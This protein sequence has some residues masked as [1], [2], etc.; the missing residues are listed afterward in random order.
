MAD[1]SD[2]LINEASDTRIP[3]KFRE[4]RFWERGFSTAKGWYH[5][6]WDG[7]DIQLALARDV[8]EAIDAEVARI[9]TV[10]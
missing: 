1:E 9:T 8:A 5:E 10:R 4:L 3:A 7:S 6:E 2:S